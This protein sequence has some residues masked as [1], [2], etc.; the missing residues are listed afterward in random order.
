MMKNNFYI[1]EAATSDLPAYVH[2]CMEIWGGKD[3]DKIFN[4]FEKSFSTFNS[5]Y[6]IA[7]IDNVTVGTGEAFPIGK[8]ISVTELNRVE[9]A[10]DLYEPG[11]EYFYIHGIEV[12]PKYRRL[13]IGLALLDYNI[14]LAQKLNCKQVCGIGIYENIDFWL[15]QG[16][17][18]EGAWQQY[19]NVGQFT[20]I[21]KQ[22]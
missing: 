12:L 6:S 9:A 8:K 18:T 3:Y 21:H 16:F 15:K 17:D 5:G 11:G 22:L 14:N 13:G 4:H 2:I 19:R 7:A 1:R 20:R 10:I